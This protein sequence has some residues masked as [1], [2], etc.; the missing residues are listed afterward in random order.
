MCRSL[1]MVT[2]RIQTSS[3]YLASRRVYCCVLRDTPFPWFELCKS[4]FGG[5]RRGARTSR[6]PTCVT[7][8][9]SN[10]RRWGWRT[11]TGKRIWRPC[12]CKWRWLVHD[13]T[14]RT[15]PLAASSDFCFCRSPAS[16]ASV[17]QDGNH[18]MPNV[19]A[20]NG[21][22]DGGKWNHAYVFYSDLRSFYFLFYSQF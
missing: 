22:K 14:A 5:S 20:I 9:C 3:G 21:N 18:V 6:S 4:A 16:S 13:S 8:R 12:R 11:R 7:G 19:R 10:R 17:R 2:Y 1:H 15:A